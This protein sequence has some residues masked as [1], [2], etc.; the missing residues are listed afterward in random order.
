MALDVLA[1][2]RSTA[3]VALVTASFSSPI[4]VKSD[5]FANA[6]A[7]LSGG[8]EQ[9]EPTEQLVAGGVQF[10]MPQSWGRLG[11]SAASGRG[12]HERVGTVVSGLC[13]GGSQGATC[14][15]GVQVT[16]IA[17][18]GEKGRKLPELEQFAAQLDAK[19][20]REFPG[21][22]KLESKERGGKHGVHWLDY[23]FSWRSGKATVHQRFAAY[24]H[25]DGSGVIAAVAGAQ[26]A[27]HVKAL[28]AFLASAVPVVDEH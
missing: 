18:S 11:A 25:D 7:R 3:L 17:Y 13:P 20:A 5:T 8:A 12:S 4:L 24:R 22:A 28:D 10:A 2:V 9:A 21:F 26:H 15:D 1:S 23:G 27:D 16:F 14:T 19:L 6:S